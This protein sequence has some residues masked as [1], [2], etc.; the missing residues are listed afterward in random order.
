MSREVR[1]EPGLI[2]IQSRA[3]TYVS[4]FISPGSSDSATKRD[5]C[6]KMTARLCQVS[7]KDLDSG[8][9]VSRKREFYGSNPISYR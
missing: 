8:I 5:K 3:M 9:A 6:R 7:S 4:Q 1:I 2:A